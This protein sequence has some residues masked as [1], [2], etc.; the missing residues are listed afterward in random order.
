MSKIIKDAMALTAITLIAGLALGGVH[1]ITE[2]PIAEQQE[3]AKVEAYQE[4]F[5]DA[6]SF[7]VVELTEDLTAQLREG[8][9]SAGYAAQEVVEI[10][11]AVDGSGNALGYAFNVVSGGGYGGDIQFSVGIQNDGTVNGIAILSIEETA[12]LGMNANTDGFK[13]QF[14]NKAVDQFTVTKTGATADGEVDALS[15]ATITTNCMVNGVN[16]GICAFNIMEG[17]N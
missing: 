14:A 15:G 10:M 9:D 3:K 4:V 11:Q 17:G 12:G 16:A 1:S 5:A 13:A 7:E 2:G 8:L 6:A